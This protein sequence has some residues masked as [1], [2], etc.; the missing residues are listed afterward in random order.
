[1]TGINV[2]EI[3]Q[4]PSSVEDVPAYLGRAMPIVATALH[5][6]SQSLLEK[7]NVVPVK[8]EEG[9]I[10]YADGTNWNPGS[11]I[12]LY[13]YRGS[14]WVKLGGSTA[15][16]LTVAE[17]GT[18]NTTLGTS[19]ALK[20]DSTGK[21]AASAVTETELGYVGG[22]TS[23]IQTQLGTKAPID[24]P[25][26]TTAANAPTP[27]VGT[28]NTSIATTAFSQER[29]TFQTVAGSVTLTALRCT[30]LLSTPIAA[31]T[32]ALPTTGVLKGDEIRLE[33]R[34]LAVADT[35]DA[36]ASFRPYRPAIGI[37]KA[38]TEIHK[39][40]GILL[41]PKVVAACKKLFRE[42]KISLYL[43]K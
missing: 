3:E 21:A 20:S 18:G 25:T 16:P 14:A 26:F 33:S 29:S 1:M 6:F 35:V 40:R 32:Q 8:L 13:Q 22:V 5:T 9:M 27:S 15:P 28:N 12:G 10:R 37:N 24:S 42:K 11:G 30:T 4:V 7:S 43:E 34:I 39:L 17:G 36:M 31:Y 23:A 2:S 19:K 41:D 38:I